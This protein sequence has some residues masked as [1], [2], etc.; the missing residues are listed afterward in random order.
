MTNQHNESVLETI[1][2]TMDRGTS[3]STYQPHQMI[4]AVCDQLIADH[5]PIAK[6]KAR[7]SHS[8]TLTIEI[9]IDVD[10][11]IF[12]K[13]YKGFPGSQEEP[14]EPAGYEIDDYKATWRGVDVTEFI[15]DEDVSEALNDLFD[16]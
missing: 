7:P 8:T 16:C 11:A 15:T 10:L 9:E 1:N 5:M 2:R 6:P 14:A 3:P 13:Y 12:A 4:N